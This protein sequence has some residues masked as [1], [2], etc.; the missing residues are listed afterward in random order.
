[1]KRLVWQKT[2]GPGFSYRIDDDGREDGAGDGLAVIGVVY[3]A[4]E[5]LVTAPVQAGDDAEDDDGER[6]HDGAM[7]KEAVS[8]GRQMETPGRGGL[9]P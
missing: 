8:E 4:A 5:L 1:M 3:A 7:S 6:G 9:L 2:M